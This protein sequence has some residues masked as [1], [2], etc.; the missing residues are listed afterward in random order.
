SMLRRAAVPS[1]ATLSLYSS[2]SACTRMSIFVFTS[3]T[4]STRLSERSFTSAAPSRGFEGLL[5]LPLGIGEGIALDKGFEFRPARR[6][7]QRPE[8]IAIRVDEL[9]RTGV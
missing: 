4:M 6:V 8:G 7:E 5:Q 1:R 3:S 9:G 2:R